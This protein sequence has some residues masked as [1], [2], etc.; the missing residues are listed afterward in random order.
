M[1]RARASRRIQFVALAAALV[2]ALAPALAE[3]R[4]GGSRSMGS[5]GARTFDSAPAT[6]TA[7]TSQPLQRSATPAP[8]SGFTNQRPGAVSP[9]PGAMQPRPSFMQRNPFLSGMIGGLVG[10]GLIGMLFGGGFGAFGGMAGFLGLLLQLALIGG[11]AYLAISFFRRRNGAGEPAYA[12]MGGGGRPGADRPRPMSYE[13]PPMA[14][15]AGRPAASPPVRDE[16]GLEKA[17]FDAF[18]QRLI[19]VQTGWTNQDVGLLRQVATPE[20]VAYFQEHL[21]TARERGVR[22]EVRDVRLLQGDLAEAWAEGEREYATVA[23]RWQAV[24]V[25]VEA[26]TGR[27]IEGDPQRPVEATE[28]WTFQRIGRHGEWLLSAIQQV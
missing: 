11:L 27:V 24:D 7:P 13:A 23:M 17:D 21:A 22:N 10:A 4:A 2:M 16:L 25:T 18:E 8:D 1:S 9:A 20:I 26:S 5:R 14:G 6:P 3:A 12:G 15:A 28:I 19:Q